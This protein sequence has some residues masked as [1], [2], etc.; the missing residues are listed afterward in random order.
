M[1]LAPDRRR[2]LAGTDAAQREAISTSASPLCVLAG[3]GSG[4]TR[5]LTRRIAWRV[6]EGSADTPHVL[7][8]TFTRKAAR[9]LR[10][11]LEALGLPEPVRAATFH[12]AALAEL[13][14]LAAA[15]G[16]APPTVLA[17]KARLLLPLAATLPALAGAE[18]PRTRRAARRGRPDDPDGRV[19][20][21]A[22]EIEWAKSR[23]VPI[24]AYPEEVERSGRTPAVETTVL[25]EA[26]RAYEREKR[27]RGLYDFEDLIAELARSCEQDERARLEL[28]W[29]HRHLFVDEYQDVTP[30]Q[31]RLLVALAGDRRDVCVVGDPNQSIYGWNGAAPEALLRFPERFPGTAVVVLDANY[32]S[33]RQIQVAC[34]AL[35]ERPGDAERPRKGAASTPPGTPEDAP[36]VPE[37]PL[38]TVRAFDSDVEEAAEV[39]AAV[40]RS[41]RPSRPWSHHAVLARTN[42]QLELLGQA[43]ADLGVPVVSS[44]STSVLSDP[45]ARAALEDLTA[46]PIGGRDALSAWARD[47]SG[48]EGAAPTELARLAADYLVLDDHPSVEGFLAYLRA[49][50]PTDRP[51]GSEDA[52]ELTTFHRA[53]G[54]EWPVVFV[55]GLEE[56][57]VPHAL[58]S[59]PAALREERRLLYVAC[60]RA[61]AELHC[62]F[63]WRRTLG[64]TERARRPSRWLPLLEE[65]CRRA[66]VERRDPVR[67]AEALASARRLLSP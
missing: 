44:R 25:L 55:T 32:R 29:R 21:L 26:W 2:L 66:V 15:R 8:L 62:S 42:A 65:A 47:L 13:R 18:G 40:R 54:L 51:G 27:R 17:D 50:P 20:L 59:E 19:A 60:S 3:A 6:A 36:P 1:D 7:A 41:R 39:A 64:G 24:D 11:R 57:L 35:I 56:G 28:H 31:E 53:K 10:E 34:E 4:K 22:R 37:G 16:E 9:E 67:A 23:D 38:P 52:V 14:H 61:R 45:A 46:R 48:E 58:A 33:T 49:G 30:L 63:A 43:L 5:V 12:S